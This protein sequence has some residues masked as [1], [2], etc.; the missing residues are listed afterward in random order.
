MKLT[1]FLVSPLKFQTLNSSVFSISHADE[2]KN[3]FLEHEQ[4]N[5]LEQEINFEEK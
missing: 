5:C 2:T 1:Y 3:K 4:C